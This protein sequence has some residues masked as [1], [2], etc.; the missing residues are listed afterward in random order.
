MKEQILEIINHN[1]YNYINKKT[2][3]KLES[4]LF[5]IYLSNINSLLSKF[6]KEIVD[7]YNSDLLINIDNIINNQYK[8][9]QIIIDN[10]IDKLYAINI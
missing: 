10:I 1:I 3:I 4:E 2:N 7:N 5:L 9:I 6:K 8:N